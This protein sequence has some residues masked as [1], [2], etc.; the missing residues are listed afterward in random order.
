[1]AP[2]ADALLGQGVT[3]AVG[4]PDSVSAALLDELGARGVPF[5]QV[6]REGEAFAIASGLWLGGATP[7]V[8]IQGTG[9]LESGDAL[10]GTATRM[11]APIVALVT[12]RGHAKLRASGVDPRALPRPRETLVRP[13]L[14]TVALFLEPTLE[15]WGVP[16]S[17]CVG[18]ADLP[19]VGEAFERAR[20]EA[21]PV[22][23]LLLPFRA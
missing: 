5:V 23:V 1:M 12:Y 8:V 11:G 4:L 13:D 14:D 9:L 15:A 20:R 2:L 10:R 22:A 18:R 21:R 19:R 17:T 6:T 16:F 3:H 7:V